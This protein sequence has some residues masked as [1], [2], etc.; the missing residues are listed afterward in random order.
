MLQGRVSH[1]V[2][3]VLSSSL[4]WIELLWH[5]WMER[6][7]MRGKGKVSLNW[8][9][10]CYHCFSGLH[11]TGPPA[12]QTPEGWLLWGRVCNFFREPWR[13]SLLYGFRFEW[14]SASWVE[15]RYSLQCSL[16][17]RKTGVNLPAVPTLLSISQFYFFL[18]QNR[19]WGRWANLLSQKLSY[20]GVIY[21]SSPCS[22]LWTSQV[23]LLD[24]SSFVW[25]EE[26]IHFSSPWTGKR[27]FSHRELWISQ[28]W[29]FQGLFFFLFP[30]HG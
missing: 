26:G 22:L 20:W 3:N 10:L 5:C 14:W 8:F 1:C 18:S 9:S 13:G 27:I 24:S 28:D 19:H 12:W 15:F 29:W 6:E 17:S 7:G 21:L 11:F 16:E 25:K 23:I 30:G 2:L 4:C